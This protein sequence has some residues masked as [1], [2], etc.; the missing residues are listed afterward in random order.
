M[1][2]DRD[3][4]GPCFTLFIIP[5]GLQLFA[6]VKDGESLQLFEESSR[7]AHKQEAHTMEAVKLVEFDLKQVL[8]RLV[9]HLFGDGRYLEIFVFQGLVVQK[10]LNIVQQITEAGF[11]WGFC[12]WFGFV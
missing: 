11:M 8:T 10:F 4:P 9:T 3:W 5:F 1:L 2:F 7:S 12:C 6:G